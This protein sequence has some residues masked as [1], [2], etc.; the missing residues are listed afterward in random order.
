MGTSPNEKTPP[1]SNRKPGVAQTA[2]DLRDR[3]R[4]SR[5][6]LHA[7]IRTLTVMVDCFERGEPRMN[8]RDGGGLD[9]KLET[10]LLKVIATLKEA[11]ELQR[12]DGAQRG[13]AV[14]LRDSLAEAFTR[15][16]G[17]SVVA[18]RRAPKARS[19]NMPVGRA[20]SGDR[21]EIDMLMA[22]QEYQQH[23]GEIL[24]QS[25]IDLTLKRAKKHVRDAQLGATGMLEPAP[26]GR[27]LAAGLVGVAEATI[28]KWERAR[29]ASEDRAAQPQQGEPTAFFGARNDMRDFNQLQ[30]RICAPLGGDGFIRTAA[31]QLGVRE[32]LRLAVAVFD[33]SAPSGTETAQQVAIRAA[34]AQLV[35]ALGGDPTNFGE[36]VDGQELGAGGLWSLDDFDHGQG[37]VRCSEGEW[38]P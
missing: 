13:A 16:I 23:T 27:E 18:R 37:L 34:M 38:N 9:R 29:R 11:A 12:E 5:D 7:A 15:A 33:Q 32:V 24:E 35:L 8:E 28:E 22:I 25:L 26:V 30:R 36:L 17:K 10:K 21:F 1:T 2:A 4:P 20:R 6:D 31:S 19:G 3:L 14:Q